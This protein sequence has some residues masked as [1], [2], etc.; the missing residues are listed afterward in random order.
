VARQRPAFSPGH[1][2]S[3]TVESADATKARGE[4]EPYV[5]SARRLAYPAVGLCIDDTVEDVPT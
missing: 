2:S 5:S 3:I 4:P 1:A